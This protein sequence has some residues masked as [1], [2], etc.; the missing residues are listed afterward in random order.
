M[1]K[2]EDEQNRY[3]KQKMEEREDKKRIILRSKDKAVSVSNTLLRK[4]KA[5]GLRLSCLLFLRNRI[6]I[7]LTIHLFKGKV[8]K[9][10]LIVF[11]NAHG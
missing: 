4:K 2:M 8:G 3:W 9:M 10:C 1:Q 5:L 6:H 11:V 7:F